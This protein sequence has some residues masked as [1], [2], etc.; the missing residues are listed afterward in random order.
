MNILDS[1][2]KYIFTDEFR[3]S[4]NY[5]IYITTDD[6]HIDDTVNYFTKE[7]IGNIHMLST[8]YYLHPVAQTIPPVESFLQKY[9]AKDFRGHARYDNSIYQHH[10]LLDCYNLYRNDWKENGLDTYIIRMRMDT[11]ITT[12]ILDSLKRLQVNPS[13][14]IMCAWDHMAIGKANIMK[15][16]C[17]GLENK[18]G[19][20][21]NTTVISTEPKVWN[22]FIHPTYYSKMEMRRWMYAP[23]RQLFEMLF[24]YCNMN[25]MDIDTCMVACNLCTIVG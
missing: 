3:T 19:T 11:M 7:N 15:W 12:N 14:E 22:N 20:Y 1:Y 16:Y 17:T 9:H 6:I 21:T 24:E 23:E 25:G 18:Y 13:L 4:C 5:R 10:K 2:N 8:N